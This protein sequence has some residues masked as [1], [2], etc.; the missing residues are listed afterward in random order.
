MQM[1]TWRPICARREKEEKEGGEEEE[2]GG[3]EEEGFFLE[4]S[5]RAEQRN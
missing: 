5:N 1:Q 4:W 2:E 3:R